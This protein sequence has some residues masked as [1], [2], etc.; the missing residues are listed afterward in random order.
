MSTFGSDCHEDNAQFSFLDLR[1]RHL[2]IQPN[3][4]TSIKN[5]EHHHRKDKLWGKI[6]SRL[7]AAVNLEA[8]S[9]QRVLWGIKTKNASF[10]GFKTRSYT[11][12]VLDKILPFLYF[13]RAGNRCGVRG[14]VR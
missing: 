6:A 1:R 9:Q 5:L 8:L 13:G 11:G 10:Q 7:E 4:I 3:L 2:F 14:Q 12:P